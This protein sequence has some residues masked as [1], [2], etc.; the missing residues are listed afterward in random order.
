[1]HFQIY[2]NIGSCSI[3]THRDKKNL[4]P[5]ISHISVQRILQKMN[6]NLRR[7]HFLVYM[8]QKRSAFLVFFVVSAIK[9][10]LDTTKMVVFV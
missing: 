4:T 3:T 9:V 2:F 6:L 10:L 7:S 1:M 8:P 5:S